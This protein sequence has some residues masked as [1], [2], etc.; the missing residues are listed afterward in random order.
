[1][2]RMCIDSSIADF[3]LI[4]V[5]KEKFSNLSE[6]TTYEE[7]SGRFSII[8]KAHDFID[9]KLEEK[10]KSFKEAHNLTMFEF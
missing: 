10:V 3:D 9:N 5:L 6:E 7:L 8:K 1:M 2:S 4:K